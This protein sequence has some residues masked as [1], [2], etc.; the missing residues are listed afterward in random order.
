[1]RFRCLLDATDQFFKVTGGKGAPI[2]PIRIEP[3]QTASRAVKRPSEHRDAAATARSAS[4]PEQYKDEL[5]E[6][7][8]KM[9]TLSDI[10]GTI[11]TVQRVVTDSSVAT[12]H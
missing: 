10:V 12:R 9:K 7:I 11:G 1:M 2:E 8:E 5:Q 4:V 3:T 6:A